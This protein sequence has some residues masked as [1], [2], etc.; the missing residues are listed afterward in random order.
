MLD[1]EKRRGKG[2]ASTEEKAAV[3][4]SEEAAAAKLWAVYVKE[5]EKYDKSLVESW[6]SDMEGMLIFAGLFS[7]SLT[8]FIIESYKTLV[9][10]SGDSTAQLLSQI[11]QQLAAAANGNTFHPPPS[12][13]FTPPAWSLICNALWFIS[14]ALSLTCALIATL[15]EQWARNFLHKTEMRSAPVIRARIFS[16]LYYGLKR[17]NMHAVVDIIPLLLHASLFFFFA[18]LVAFLIPINLGIALLAAVLL[19]IISVVYSLLTLLPLRY[20]DCPFHTPFSGAFWSISRRLTKMWGRRRREDVEDA[21][22]TSNSSVAETI[23]EVMSHH[24]TEGSARSARDYRA[25]VWTVKSLADDSE[26]EPLVEAIPDVLWGP[27]KRRYAY[28]DAIQRLMRDPDLKLQSRVEGLLISCDSGLLSAEAA[29]RRRIACC[30]A[31]WAIASLQC[32]PNSQPHPEALDFSTWGSYFNPRGTDADHYS[33]SVFAMM[34]WCTFCRAKSDLADLSEYLARCEAGVKPGPSPN[35]QPVISYLKSLLSTGI[36]PVDYLV[37]N[38]TVLDFINGRCRI[39]DPDDIDPDDNSE[40]ARAIEDISINTP[41]RIMLEYF[42]RLALVESPPYRWQETE[43]PISLDYS[44]PFSAFKENLEVTLH[45]VVS[46]HRNILNDAKAHEWTDIILGKLCSWWQPDQTREPTPIPRALIHYL[47]TRTSDAALTQLAFANSIV[48]NLWTAF[49]ITL[50]DWP[51]GSLEVELHKIGIDEVLTALW[52][53]SS[54]VQ[55]GS[56]T[57]LYESALEAVLKSRESSITVSVIVMLKAKILD[58]LVYFGTARSSLR[59]QL[60]PVQTAIV[61]PENFSSADEIDAGMDDAHAKTIHA[62]VADRV[63]EAKIAL[64]AE[65]L[66]GLDSGPLPYKAIET[67]RRIGG[68]IPRGKIHESHQIRFAKGMDCVLRVGDSYT[69]AELLEA[70][71]ACQVF[72]LL[73]D[74]RGSTIQLFRVKSKR[75]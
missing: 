65:F 75:F 64:L 34:A 56:S 11:S 40:L 51:P 47:N 9:P 1:K 68:A 49:P 72:E 2:T 63:N 61:D 54:L 30:K 33:A 59:H 27:E 62:L 31:L 13:Q 23:V 4:P 37:A 73:T 10:D 74:T 71:I 25:L 3:D 60:L 22:T 41:H 26:L 16:Y 36:L 5:A 43:D 46:G 24:A 7:A 18:G 12:V 21:P 8:A 29:N 35:L 53:V 58:S 20:L 52:R 14:L 32:L 66:E 42:R 19:V 55:W 39:G 67:I 57:E 44:A 45:N 28:E 6:K 38:G 15:L 50:T 17:F 69:S 48:Y 70:L